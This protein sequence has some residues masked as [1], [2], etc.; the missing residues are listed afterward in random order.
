MSL[1]YTMLY[2]V[3]W[4]WFE[5][6]VIP[7]WVVLAEVLW[8]GK[9]N[10]YLDYVTLPFKMNGGLPPSWKGPSI[11][12]LL[13][14]G[15]LISSRNSAILLSNVGLC[16]CVRLRRRLTPA[17]HLGSYTHACC[18]RTEVVNNRGSLSTPTSHFI[19]LLI[20]HLSCD[21]CPILLQ[22]LHCRWWRPSIELL[23]ACSLSRAH[24]FLL[25]YTVHY[26]GSPV[27]KGKAFWPILYSL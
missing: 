8:V 14:S 2:A 9:E 18:A 20:Y 3:L 5:P 16:C 19:C 12:I 10:P 23:H 7:R 24:F 22:H 13:P 15:W 26:S 6:S 27:E 4:Q 25:C 11:A 21:G 1:L 17:L